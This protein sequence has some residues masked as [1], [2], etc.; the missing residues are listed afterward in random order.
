MK[1]D[2]ELNDNTSIPR[3]LSVVFSLRNEEDVLA[4]LIERTRNVLRPLQEKGILSG[5]ELIFVNDNSN[6]NSL[7]VLIDCAQG[8]NDIRVINMSRRFGVSPCVM[9]GFA[10]SRGDMVVYMDADL[11]DP[12]ELLPRLIE[13]MIE[14][15]VDIV[16]TVRESRKGEPILKLWLTGLGY[17]ILNKTSHINLPK[18]SG[19]FKLLSRRAINHLLRLQEYRPFMRGLV[20]WIGFP[21]EFV[22]YVREARHKGKTKFSVL[23][24]DVISNFLDSALISFSSAPLKMAYF[25][26]IM[27][28]VCDFLIA[29]HVFIEKF[30]GRAVPGW[31]GIMMTI[32]F[33]SGVQLFSMGILGLYMYS[34]YE[35]TKNRPNYIVE[36]TIG[37]PKTEGLSESP[38]ALIKNDAKP[39]DGAYV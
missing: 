33:F 11:Q 19:D 4:A 16:H 1:P 37:F 25:F 21:Q 26:G 12:P 18:E 7:K 32:L 6:D 2:E 35:Q 3:T 36:S 9:A 34:I 13:V 27:A 10:Y 14:K 15:K 17:W 28:I 22:P 24:R 30:S 38:P 5:Y 8:H 29:V 20:C 31:A 39:R 23:S